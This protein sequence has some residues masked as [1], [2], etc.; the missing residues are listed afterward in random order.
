MPLA[1]VGKTW[2]G[3]HPVMWAHAKNPHKLL[4]KAKPE[5]YVPAHWPVKG[6]GA[7]KYPATNIQQLPKSNSNLQKADLA[8]ADMLKGGGLLWPSKPPHKVASKICGFTVPYDANQPLCVNWSELTEEQQEIVKGYEHEIA[9][10][11]VSSAPLFSAKT[12]KE[13]ELETKEMIAEVKIPWSS[14]APG[15]ETSMQWIGVDHAGGHVH[16]FAHSEI[17]Q[18]K[19]PTIDEVKAMIGDA[20]KEKVEPPIDDDDLVG[21]VKAGLDLLTKAGIFLKSVDVHHNAGEITVGTIEVDLHQFGSAS[22]L[23][24][25]VD[26][27]QQKKPK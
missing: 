24:M 17:K 27:M 8:L 1:F 16:S 26:I 21:L 9:D 13:V 3:V 5:P 23:S 2:E 10:G 20:F 25:A 22:A 11:M 12:K 7:I 14:L 15:D 18:E 4:K 19:P 6:G